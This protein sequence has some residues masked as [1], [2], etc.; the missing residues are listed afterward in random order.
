MKK[1]IVTGLPIPKNPVKLA[2]F[3]SL[4][5][6]IFLLLNDSFA[7]WLTLPASMIIVCAVGISMQVW[8][9]KCVAR[10]YKDVL[11][12]DDNRRVYKIHKLLEIV[13][14]CAIYCMSFVLLDI[15]F[16]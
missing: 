2:R 12:E 1:Y 13:A 7:R 11:D 4:F 10:R 14:L 16:K 3:I 9:Y 6:F 8:E 15:F 5:C